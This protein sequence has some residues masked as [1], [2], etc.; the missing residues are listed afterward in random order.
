MSGASRARR[1][2]LPCRAAAEAARRRDAWL[3]LLPHMTARERRTLLRTEPA[4]ARYAEAL[5]AA[6][7]P[8]RLAFDDV[9]LDVFAG[10]LAALHG[11]RM[12]LIR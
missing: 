3:D 2:P 5:R 11:E 7:I 6:G 9:A 8:Q 12:E 4:A 1:A 10:V